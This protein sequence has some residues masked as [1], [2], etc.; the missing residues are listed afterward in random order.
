MNIYKSV[1]DSL[2]TIITI[3]L[4]VAL[5]I[6]CSTKNTSKD[7]STQNIDSFNSSENTIINTSKNPDTLANDS[8]NHSIITHTTDSLLVPTMTSS[9]NQSHTYIQSHENYIINDV[10]ETSHNITSLNNKEEDLN[11]KKVKTLSVSLEVDSVIEMGKSVSLIVSI[12]DTSQ[13]VTPNKSGVAI[14]QKS[15][16]AQAGNKVKIK[17]NAPNF[18]IDSLNNSCTDC[19]VINDDNEFGCVVSLTPTI[20]GK[21]KISATVYIFENDC[22]QFSQQL[23]AES[24]N[25]EVQINY[26]AEIFNA[27]WKHFT[28]FW[29]SLLTVLFG[30]LLL[31]IK[32]KL[33][34]TK[35][36]KAE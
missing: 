31:F 2:F 19:S 20:K 12:K 26:L 5:T 8:L 11:S 13:H 30:S 29:G 7:D 6:A 15:I 34:G 18:I 14:S 33:R 3:I 23:T 4:I 36:E 16:K 1:S 35:K 22:N 21:S 27:T 10:K 32:K 17:I 25:I 9:Y 24:L 28:T